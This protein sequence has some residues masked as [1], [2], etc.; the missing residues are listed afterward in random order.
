VSRTAMHLAIHRVADAGHVAWHGP[1]IRE[2]V[3]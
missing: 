3:E 2:G 1:R